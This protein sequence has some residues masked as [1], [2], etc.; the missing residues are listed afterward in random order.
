MQTNATPEHQWLKKLV[1]KWAFESHC[2]AAPGEEPMRAQG[3]E[4]FRMLGDLWAIG[5][6]EGEMPGCGMMN[7]VLTIGFD[8]ARGSF[9]GSW[10]GSPMTTMF[11][12][13]GTL[14]DD[15][16]VLTLNTTGPDFNDATKT[17]TY[18]DIIEWVSDDERHFRSEV[19]TDEGWQEMMHATH[20][21]IR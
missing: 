1:G 21:R 10:V 6:S 12:Y 16:R 7:A 3:T 4:T 8:P 20:R 13:E 18:R 11:I 19:K 17:A 14:D 15:H 9:V 5:E 2:P